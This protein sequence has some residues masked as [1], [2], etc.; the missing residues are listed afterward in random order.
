M[1]QSQPVIL[2]QK[3]IVVIRVLPSQPVR[4]NIEGF[5]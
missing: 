2:P 4:K 1:E 3:L 5:D